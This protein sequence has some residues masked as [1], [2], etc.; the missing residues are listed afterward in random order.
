MDF[1]DI[2]DNFESIFPDSWLTNEDYIA[3]QIIDDFNLPDFTN[4]TPE[5]V[6]NKLYLDGQWIAVQKLTTLHDIMFDENN[7]VD[8]I[9][10]PKSFRSLIRLD[11]R[12]TSYKLN[13]VYYFQKE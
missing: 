9:L 8:F 11:R 12:R 10:V 4:P 1:I 6:P 3:S 5:E 13:N 7:N 2:D